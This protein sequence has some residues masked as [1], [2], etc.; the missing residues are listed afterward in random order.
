MVLVRPDTDSLFLLNATAQVLWEESCAGI[1]PNATARFFSAEFG[2]PFETA[3]RDVELTLANWSEGL[4]A[5]RQPSVPLVPPSHKPHP[6]T[7]SADY[8]FN[9]GH[10]RVLLDPGDLID[11]VL[12]RLLSLR[13]SPASPAVRFSLKE[14]AGRFW[15]FRDE[16]CLGSEEYTSGARTLLLQEM[17]RLCEPGRE[18]RAILHA[19]ACGDESGCILFAGESYSG[20][21]TLCAALMCAGLTCYS[22]DSA[23]IDQDF[24]IAGM[25]FPLMLRQGSWSALLPRFPELKD[26]RVHRR[27]GVDVRFLPSNLPPVPPLRF[28]PKPSFSSTT[29]SPHPRG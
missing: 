2:I 21:S 13:S 4:L 16:V 14:H 6:A 8:L 20:K 15:V 18:W 27:W 1:S 24:R 26:T 25:P 11:E 28:P 29:S 23:A 3:L 7:I 17:T 9:Q 12:P 22:D 10:F 5:G 19:G